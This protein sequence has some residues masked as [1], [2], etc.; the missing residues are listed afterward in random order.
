MQVAL[1][2]PLACSWSFL[3]LS[4]EPGESRALRPGRLVNR[5]AA[6]PPCSSMQLSKRPDP[7]VFFNGLYPGGV[8]VKN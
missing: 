4:S 1:S 8:I 2:V 6:N 3:L 5:W 7:R